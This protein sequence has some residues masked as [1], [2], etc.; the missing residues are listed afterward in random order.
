MN[1]E[2]VIFQGIY[3]LLEAVALGFLVETLLFF[4]VIVFKKKLS[5]RLN[6]KEMDRAAVNLIKHIGL[7]W[8]CVSLAYKIFEVVS[9]TDEYEEYAFYNRTFGPYWFAYWLTSP[10]MFLLTQLLWIERFSSK[11]LPRLMIGVFIAFSLFAEEIVIF[12][13]SLH[14]DYLPSSWRDSYVKLLSTIGFGILI[15]V[16]IWGLWFVLGKYVFGKPDQEELN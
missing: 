8:L 1:F 16:V 11:W 10:F 13:S 2:A 6:L 15:F 12:M 5:F 7:L 9:L 3:Y 4:P 14:R